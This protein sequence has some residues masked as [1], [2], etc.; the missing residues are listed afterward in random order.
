MTTVYPNGIDDSTS[1]PLVVDLVTPITAEVINRLREAIV[2]IENELG[3]DPSREFATVRARLDYLQGL[4]DGYAV[5]G[6][7]L[8]TVKDHDTVVSTETSTLN[9]T[10]DGVSVFNVGGGQS[11]V[12]INFNLNIVQETIAVTF[13]GQT[14]ITLS[15]TP[16]DPATVQF[17][18]NGNKLQYG[19]N[20]T[21]VGNIVLYSGPISL[22]ISDSLEF[23]YIVTG[24]DA[25][26]ETIAVNPGSPT[27]FTL[28][29]LPTSADAVQM[30]INGNKQELATEYGAVNYT[31]TYTGPL[32]LTTS[33]IVEFWYVTDVGGGGGSGGGSSL[34][35][36][37]T[38][39]DGSAFGPTIRAKFSVNN[40]GLQDLGALLDEV[41]LTIY[42]QLIQD[43][44]GDLNQRA[45]TQFTGLVSVS[46]DAGNDRTIVNIP[47]AVAGD[48]DGYLPNPNVVAIHSGATQ[49]NIGTLTSG[50]FLYRNGSNIESIAGTLN[51]TLKQVLYNGNVTD[52]Y[53]IVISSGDSLTAANNANLNIKSADVTSGIAGNVNIYAGSSSVSNGGNV[54]IK[55][56]S[57]SVDGYIALQDEDYNDAVKIT[58]SNIYFYKDLISNNDG[59]FYGNL[60]VAGKLT[61][62]G[63][64]DPTGLVLTEQ[65]SSPNL[66][67]TG[68]GTIWVKN[69]SPT[70]LKFTDS[71]NTTHSLFTTS[72][73]LGG[74]LDGYLPNPNVVAVHSG[75]TQLLIGSISANQLVKRS[76]TFLIGISTIDATLH[77]NQTDGYLHSNVS[78][79]ANGFTP[80]VGA[81]GTVLTSTGTAATWSYNNPIVVSDT[82]YADQNDYTF[83]G[84]STCN[85][86]RVASNDG[87]TITGFDNSVSQ[88]LKKLINVGSNNILLSH[89]N[90]SSVD[91]NRLIIPG[92]T[93][94]TLQPND[95]VD[96]FYDTISER[97]RI[98][99]FA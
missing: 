91:T 82:I 29:S 97:W 49:L 89:Q 26:Q 95:M 86:A 34:I 57:G 44:S 65:S 18:L 58:N 24:G 93:D 96:M 36:E 8:I 78:D 48:L 15:Y 45:K 87:Y 31:V 10:G 90:V 32:S 25:I 50:E 83:T 54:F 5:E 70:T 74:D 77:G 35:F 6:F 4:I 71:A 56:G 84:F 7:G 9:F 40:G 14:Q 42:N 17:Y 72:A 79:T 61:V 23:F 73:P 27:V 66:A 53:N 60:G 21:C 62:E 52:G 69:D 2:V 30:F 16:K 99:V 41:Q 3:L 12:N 67:N 28:S 92:N 88:I 94:M 81:V 98:G 37:G 39:I 13:N 46:D 20:Y 51:P 38:N 33:D 85:I 76:G 43:G 47:T 1:L 55:P 80:A 59:Y 63:L 19:V 11:D 68:K 22:L 64:I 75:A